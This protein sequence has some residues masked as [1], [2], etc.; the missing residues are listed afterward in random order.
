LSMTSLMPMLSSAAKVR[1]SSPQGRHKLLALGP[2]GVMIC[3]FSHLG[4][5]STRLYVTMYLYKITRAPRRRRRHAELL[6][7]DSGLGQEGEG[8]RQ[9][10]GEKDEPSPWSCGNRPA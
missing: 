5:C 1:R 2:R 9:D 3:G 10:T 8:T 4:T 7:E 6:K